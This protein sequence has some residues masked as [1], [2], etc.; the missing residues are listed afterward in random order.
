MWDDSLTPEQ[1]D[2]FRAEFRRRRR[3]W[4]VVQAL[5]FTALL[6]LASR[7]ARAGEPLHPGVFLILGLIAWA[8]ALGLAWVLVWRCPRCGAPLGRSWRPAE[9]RACRAPLA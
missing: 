7:F 1:V 3:Q 4:F 2:R 6:L 8:V 9:C 5:A